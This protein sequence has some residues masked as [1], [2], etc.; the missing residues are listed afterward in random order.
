MQLS[1]EATYS[2]EFKEKSESYGKLLFFV[3]KVNSF[4]FEHANTHYNQIR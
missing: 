4:S 3:V 2:L 1:F